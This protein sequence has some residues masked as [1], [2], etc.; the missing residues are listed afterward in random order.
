MRIFSHTGICLFG[1]H[2]GVHATALPPGWVE[3]ACR[4][5]KDF[6]PAYQA[7]RTTRPPHVP[8]KRDGSLPKRN[9]TIHAI[10]RRYQP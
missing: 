6:K 1:A 2:R 10:K 8:K 4:N 9:Y 3:W 7:A 5:V